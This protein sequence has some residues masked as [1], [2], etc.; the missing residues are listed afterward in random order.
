MLKFVSTKLVPSNV[1]FIWRPIGI[2]TVAPELLEL[3]RFE[4]RIL[5]GMPMKAL[6]KPVTY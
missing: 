2:L 6:K 1:S 3:L 4:C 5:G